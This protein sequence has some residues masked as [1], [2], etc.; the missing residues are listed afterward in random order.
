MDNKVFK[1]LSS[2]NLDNV[3][4]VSLQDFEKGDFD[5][6]TAKSNRSIVEYY[7]TCTPSIILYIFKKYGHINQLTYL[8]ADLFFFSDPKS[9]FDEIGSSSIAIIEHRYFKRY[10]SMVDYGIFNVGWMTFN[11]DSN[12]LSAL[13]WWR[14][15]CNEWCYKELSR[16]RYADQKYL[17]NW[18]TLFKN[19]KTIQHKG[20]NLATWN[21][22]NYKISKKNNS[23]F[24]D[25][26]P[27]VFFHFHGFHKLI[28]NYYSPGYS[29]TIV[30][31]TIRDEV[32][33][34]YLAEYK[35]NSKLSSH[36][37]NETKFRLRNLASLLYR[38]LISGNYAK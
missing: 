14:K 12:S 29:Q 38:R 31:K 6:T 24:V 9:I 15:K 1:F 37:N 23:I 17:D 11:K 26:D 30:N 27:L 5:L 28:F 34:P 8:D 33:G 13:N 35:L 4:L 21:I 3:K 7:F 22:E 25:D 20:A 18:P 2:Q 16:G 10:R 19:V 36:K 32:Y